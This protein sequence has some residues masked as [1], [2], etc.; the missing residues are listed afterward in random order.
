M[1]VQ[2]MYE[3]YMV[4]FIKSQLNYL[5]F[6]YSFDKNRILL[7]HNPVDNPLNIT[8]MQLKP[9]HVYMFKAIVYIGLYHLFIYKVD[10]GET[11]SYE[12]IESAY[13]HETVSSLALFPLKLIPLGINNYCRTS[14]HTA[15]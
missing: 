10:M 9:S 12:C 5:P 11:H 15:T 7:H 4:N 1:K 2:I 8:D 14:V 3:L 13:L 6:V